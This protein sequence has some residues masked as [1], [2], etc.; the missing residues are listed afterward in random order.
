MWDGQRALRYVRH[1][2]ARFNI[3]PNRV[4]IFGFSAGGHLASTIA[5]HFDQ[6]FSLLIQDDVDKTDARPDFLGLGYPVISMDPHQY[7]AHSSLKHLLYGY[8]GNQLTNLESFLSGHKHVNSNTPPTFIFE[9]IDDRQINAQNSVLFV[10]ALQDAGI[11]FK[12]LIFEHGKHGAGLAEH[13]STECLWPKSFR[14]W[15]VERKLISDA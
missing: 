2:A 9:S 1:N 12:A 10:M 7:A 8:T 11:P 5:L 3:N 15:L 4:G 13:E 6:N 14:N